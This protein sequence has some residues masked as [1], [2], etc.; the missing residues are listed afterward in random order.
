MP[1]NKAAY[2]L[3]KYTQLYFSEKSLTNIGMLVLL[4]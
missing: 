1:G 4:L 3:D 2:K